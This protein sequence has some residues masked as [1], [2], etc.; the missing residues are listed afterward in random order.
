MTDNH[1]KTIDK[2]FE[3]NLWANTKLIELCMDLDDEQLSLEVDGAYGGI[4]AFLSHIVSAEGYYISLLSGTSFWD[5]NLNWDNLPLETISER[6]K[7]SG[8][9]LIEIASKSD[10]D[11]EHQNRTADKPFT[12][13]NWTVL[14]QAMTHAIEH[15]AHV[16][17]LLT[18]LGIDHPD[19][20]LWYYMQ[21]F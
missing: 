4:R 12:F 10:P 11:T 1:S 18:H 21:Q 2:M 19:L 9:K 8:Q 7:Q 20:S 6:A 3:Y 16:K 14:A 17:V 15:R 5:E 13:Y